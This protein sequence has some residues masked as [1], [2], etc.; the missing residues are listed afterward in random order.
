MADA[1]DY[2]QDG[3]EP[4]LLVDIATLTGACVVALGKDAAGLFCDDDALAAALFE[5][6]N[7]WANARGGCPFGIRAR[8]P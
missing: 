8:R 3:R 6:A 4:A 1:L 2:G 7:A 5:T